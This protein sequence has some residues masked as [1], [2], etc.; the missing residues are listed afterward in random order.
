MA[1]DNLNKMEQGLQAIVRSLR[2]DPQGTPWR[3][4]T[5]FSGP[6]IGYLWAIVRNALGEILL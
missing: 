6:P 1:G 4:E 5:R 2:T 3:I